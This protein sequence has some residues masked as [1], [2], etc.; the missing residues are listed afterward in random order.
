[1]EPAAAL[2]TAHLAPQLPGL[3]INRPRGGFPDLH[4]W[5]NC[6]GLAESLGGAS[7]EDIGPVSRWDIGS[8]GR[9]AS[10]RL[11]HLGLPLSSCHQ[12]SILRAVCCY[13]WPPQLLC[14]P[15]E[16]TVL[17]RYSLSTGNSSLGSSQTAEWGL[18]PPPVPWRL[19]H[20]ISEHFPQAWPGRPGPSHSPLRTGPG[21]TEV[22]RA[23]SPLPV[24]PPPTSVVLPPQQWPRAVLVGAELDH[25]SVPAGLPPALPSGSFLPFK[26][27]ER[28]AQC[29]RPS[30]R[31]GGMGHGVWRAGALLGACLLGHVPLL[32][33]R[34]PPCLSLASAPW[35]QPTGCSECHWACL[36]GPGE[37]GGTGL[38]W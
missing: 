4:S 9:R 3:A 13:P 33:P 12:G 16:P 35:P 10:C 8:S 6:R 7:P 29:V 31:P 21:A 24:G 26:S 27:W 5:Q 20:S 18:L 1:M 37:P 17:P 14:P 25:V 19:G 23:G 22:G 34:L 2:L 11:S 15:W 32:P 30:A 36:M 38:V 28:T